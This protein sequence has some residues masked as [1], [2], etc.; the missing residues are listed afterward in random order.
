M[1][2]Q[3]FT[4][5]ELR[6]KFGIIPK[7]PE[8]IKR[9]R[10]H[11]GWWRLS[12]LNEKAG[13]NPARPIESV[14]NTIE[15]GE[16]SG[17]NF[18]TENTFA[19]IQDT[20]KAR[21]VDSIGKIETKRLYNNLLSSQ[22]LCFNFFAELQVNKDLGLAIL[23]SL[24]SDVTKLNRVLFEYCPTENY[25]QDGSAFDVAFDVDFGDKKGFIGLECKYTDSF[26]F[27]PSKSDIYY[28]DKGNKNYET[29]FKVFTDNKPT[30]KDDYFSY[31]LNADFNQLFRSQ[32]MAE[33][34]LQ[35]KRYDIVKTGI[36]CFQDDVGSIVSGTAFKNKLAD[37]KFKVITYSEFIANAQKL[38]LTWH[39][40]EWTMML[41][42][43]YCGLG[44]SESVYNQLR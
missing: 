44:L 39:Q 23:Q 21:T 15:E 35:H 30:F 16:I 38:N 28:G 29:Y 2:Y 43:R 6:E 17:K 9:I 14:C 8:F 36:F 42:A 32:L 34:M 24:W 40:R 19:V 27:K 18:L 4:S 3:P 22:P 26:S 13:K 20:L 37:G 11:Q 10:I 33:A 25:T 7:S 41:W 12:V 5:G 1:E 31:V